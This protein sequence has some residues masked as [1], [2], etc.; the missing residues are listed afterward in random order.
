MS[1]EKETMMAEKIG[2][3][4]LAEHLSTLASM[5]EAEWIRANTLGIRLDRDLAHEAREVR[6]V[7]D[8]LWDANSCVVLGDE[9]RSTA[10][11]HVVLQFA[12]ER[13]RG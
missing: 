6:R 12:E 2:T 11:T 9:I 8:R 10:Q 13:R 4:Y 5:L 3:R 7:A 1:G